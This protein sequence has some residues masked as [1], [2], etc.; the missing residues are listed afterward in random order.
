MCAGTAANSYFVLLMSNR[1]S[2][3]MLENMSTLY[4]V[5]EWNIRIWKSDNRE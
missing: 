2:F 3:D 1:A 5:G 4:G